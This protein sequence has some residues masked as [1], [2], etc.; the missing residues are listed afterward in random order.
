MLT[1]VAVNILGLHMPRQPTDKMFLF[2]FKPHSCIE[3]HNNNYNYN[4]IF[5]LHS[6]IKILNKKVKNGKAIPV[7]GRGGP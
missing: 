6:F 3:G 1:D 7:T 5:S 2:M 4:N